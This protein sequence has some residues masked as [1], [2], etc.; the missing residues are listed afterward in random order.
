MR[1]WRGALWP[2]VGNLHFTFLP[3]PCFEWNSR[4]S[5]GAYCSS[6]NGNQDQNISWQPKV[7]NNF[8]WK[9]GFTFIV[10]YRMP[11]PPNL[12]ETLFSSSNQGYKDFSKFRKKCFKITPFPTPVKHWENTDVPKQKE[13][14]ITCFST[15][16]RLAFWYC[17]L[18]ILN[19]SRL[20]STLSKWREEDIP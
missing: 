7:I 14:N 10:S 6:Y 9:K 15:T 20:K 19:F 18:D 12:V 17:L 4:E 2:S 3:G 11:F 16:P 5:S 1:G 8:G 13:I